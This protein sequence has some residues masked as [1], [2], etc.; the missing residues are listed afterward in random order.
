M[1]RK[2]R[3][4]LSDL[5]S[6]RERER[7]LHPNSPEDPVEQ[8]RDKPP[9]NAFLVQRVKF[10]GTFKQIHVDAVKIVGDWQQCVQTGQV[11]S[12]DPEAIY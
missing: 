2:S 5:R 3:P 11:F 9:T 8:R 4:F 12:I 6:L 10:G 1:Q 7:L